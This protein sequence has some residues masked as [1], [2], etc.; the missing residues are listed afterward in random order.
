M[1]HAPHCGHH[2][3][4]SRITLNLHKIRHM[5]TAHLTHAP[6]VIADEVHNHQVLCPVLLAA[7]QGSCRRCIS[8]WITLHARCRPFDGPGLQNS[9]STPAQKPFR[10]GTTN[11]GARQPALKP[12][13]IGGRVKSA[14]G[15]VQASGVRDATSLQRCGE[16][17][18]VALPFVQCPLARPH[19][20]HVLLPAVAQAEG[21][22]L[23]H[24]SLTLIDLFVL[25]HQRLCVLQTC[26]HRTGWFIH[27]MSSTGCCALPTGNAC[28]PGRHSWH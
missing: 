2:L 11:C 7:C 10:G 17:D 3:V 28:S 20:V 12:C 21:W 19:V 25:V 23:A 6:Q 13:G 5:H 27:W 16:A 14:Q 15:V 22:Q 18:F 24:P 4:H 26:C 1:P 9:A 8:S